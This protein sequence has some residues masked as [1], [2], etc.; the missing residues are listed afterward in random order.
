MTKEAVYKYLF[1]CSRRDRLGR[2]YDVFDKIKN[3]D[4]FEI[5]VDIY[6]DMEYHFDCLDDG[7]LKFMKFLRPESMR[8]EIAAFADADGYIKVYRGKCTKSTSYKKALSWTLDKKKAEWF[9]RRFQFSLDDKCYLY[10]GRVH[11]DNVVAYISTRKE[12]ELVCLRSSVEKLK[13]ERIIYNK[14][15]VA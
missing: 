3:D 8:A 7:L 14:K 9:A 13:V 6:S 12:K 2:Y 15:G 1:A 5:F 10:T 11:V 4:H